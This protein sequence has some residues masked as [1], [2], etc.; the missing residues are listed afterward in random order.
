LWRPIDIVEQAFAMT[1]QTTVRIRTRAAIHRLIALGV[2]LVPVIL[3]A[4]G[5]DNGGAGGY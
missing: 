4:C 2:V 3:A 5:G 1:T